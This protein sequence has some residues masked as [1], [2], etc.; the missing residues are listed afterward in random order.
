MEGKT[1]DGRRRQ[2]A[3]G[4]DNRLN[5]AAATQP[6]AERFTDSL[7]SREKALTALPLHLPTHGDEYYQHQEECALE[8]RNDDQNEKRRHR[9]RVRPR[10]TAS[11]AMS[12]RR[13]M[14]LVM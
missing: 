9:A 10:H 14:G 13:L 4:D 8:K 7:A 3:Q 11:F 5:F 6:R 1:D 2:R 12:T